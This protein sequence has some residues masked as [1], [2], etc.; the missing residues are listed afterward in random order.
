MILPI[1]YS[2]TFFVIYEE[3]F[4]FVLVCAFLSFEW[5]YESEVFSQEKKAEI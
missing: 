1:Y 5:G 2:K 4:C 3:T